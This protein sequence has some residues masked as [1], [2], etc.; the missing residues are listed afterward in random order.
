MYHQAALK[1]KDQQAHD[2]AAERAALR[3]DLEKILQERGTLESMRRLV[4]AAVTSAA[5]AAGN[6]ALA[7][8]LS[9]PQRTL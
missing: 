7:E 2:A 1:L 5:T 4:A 6:H 9:L 3:R 8:D